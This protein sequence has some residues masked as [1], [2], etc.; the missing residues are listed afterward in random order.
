MW[1]RNVSEGL[2]E[3]REEG[4]RK[5]GRVVFESIRKEKK[6]NYGSRS[7]REKRS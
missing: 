1:P 7:R 5:E 4:K 3:K 2:K 6:K